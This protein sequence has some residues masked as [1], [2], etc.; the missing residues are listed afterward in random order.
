[1][2]SCSNGQLFLYISNLYRE[3]HFFN[4]REQIVHPYNLWLGHNSVILNIYNY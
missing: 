1:M 4:P 3:C 2:K